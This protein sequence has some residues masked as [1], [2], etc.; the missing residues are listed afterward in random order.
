[1]WEACQ[2]CKIMGVYRIFTCEICTESM[3][4]NKIFRNEN[5][6]KHPFCQE[7]IAK[8]IESK[9]QDSNTAKIKCPGLRCEQFLDPFSCKSM[10]PP[11][12]FSKWYG[13]LCED[14]VLGLKEAT[15]PTEIAWVWW[16]MSVREK[17][18]WRK[19]GVPIVSDGSVSGASRIGMLGTHVK[20]LETWSGTGM[21]FCLGVL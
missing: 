8:Y 13:I 14:Y 4:T 11:S 2:G 17:V 19:L 9:V 16:W 21:I 1:M 10:I 15:A 6:C 12:L 20:K 7:C 18:R 5:L 3:S